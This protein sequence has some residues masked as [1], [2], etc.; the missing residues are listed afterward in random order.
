MDITLGE[1]KEIHTVESAVAFLKSKTDCD[2]DLAIEFCV[3]SHIGQKRKSGEDYAVHP[4]I[5]ASFVAGFG[6]DDAMMKAAL[7]HDVVEDTDCTHEDVVNLFGEDV[8]ILVDALTKI[9]EIR[10]HE[11]PASASDEKLIKAALSFRKMLT[12]AI[13]D[14]RA[15]VIKLCDRTHNLL[16]LGAL[17]PA[18]QKRIAEESLVVYA[19]IAYKLGISKLKNAI[20]DL[21]LMALFPDIYARIDGYFRENDQT[22]A[23]KLNDIVSKIEG[24][25]LENGFRREDFVIKSRQKHYFSIY[26]KIQRKGVSLEEVLDLLAVRIIVNTKLECYKVLGLLHTKFKPLIGRFKDY[27]AIPKDNG[28]QTLHTT[29]FFNNAIFEAQIR[30]YEMDEI[31]ELGPAAHLGYKS[32]VATD[33]LKWL[34]TF[35]YQSENVEEFYELAKNDLY[36]DEIFVFSP[37]GKAYALPTGATALDFAYAVHTDLGNKAQDAYI[38]NIRAPLLQELKLGDICQIIKAE[39][40]IP[41]CTWINA[42]KTSRAK[43]AMKEVCS[44]KMRYID[45]RVAKNILAHTFGYDYFKLRNWLDTT[46][47]V[48]SVHRVAKDHQYYIDMVKKITEETSIRSK[49]LFTRLMGIKIKKFHIEHL[50]FYSAKTVSEVRFDV[51]CQPKK[52]DDIVAF[53][54]KGK[55][56]IHHKLCASADKMIA[57]HEPMVFVEWAVDKVRSYSLV[58]SLQNKKGAL[59]EFVGFLAKNDVNIVS[60]EIGN[61]VNPT[62]Y[63]T[64]I[65][66]IKSDFKAVREKIARQ[67]KLIELAST[68]DAFRE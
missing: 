43:K 17:T 59:A 37:K 62:E 36:S 13:A 7:L 6:G 54:Q 47:Y 24:L 41:R 49:S 55:A 65:V 67:F 9:S 11:L 28:Y 22:I 45:R 57:K 18:K 52:H 33:S 2:L 68:D 12:T 25:L 31:A 20:E 46:K 66:E 53:Y 61:S 38:N 10:T 51:C 63:C 64:A 39:E 23:I 26:Q 48:D 21:S 30:T 44:H 58:V 3:K 15:L 50:D 19:P 34:K 40:D 8:A 1:A 5:V 56:L 32:G 14:P 35:E 29:M 42:V 27:I 4:I 16:T 60:L